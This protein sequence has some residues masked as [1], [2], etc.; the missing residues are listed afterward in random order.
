MLLSAMENLGIE[1]VILESISLFGL[2][3]MLFRDKLYR[4]PLK[5]ELRTANPSL[6]LLALEIGA[7]VS[8]AALNVLLNPSAS[9]KLTYFRMVS[10]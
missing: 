9:A 7:L 2:T 4:E 1:L 8:G 6:V 5:L 3:I 10:L